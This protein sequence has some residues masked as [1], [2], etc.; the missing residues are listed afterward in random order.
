M[1]KV[2][3]W[4]KKYWGLLVAG[5][6]FILGAIIFGGGRRPHPE[7]EKPPEDPPDPEVATDHVAAHEKDK[8]R[9]DKEIDDADYNDII[10]RTNSQ[11]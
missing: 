7:I 10:D 4:V 9:T 6:G 5:V 1:K 3:E 8:A 11:Y 2:I